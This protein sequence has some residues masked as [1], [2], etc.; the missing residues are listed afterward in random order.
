MPIITQTVEVCGCLNL[1]FLH[2]SYAVKIQLVKIASQVSFLSGMD[3][4][5][6]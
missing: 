1:L 5:L 6:V 2:T 4:S 3:Y